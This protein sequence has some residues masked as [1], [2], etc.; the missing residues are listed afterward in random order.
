MRRIA[1]RAEALRGTVGAEAAATEIAAIAQLAAR[2]EA[3][4]T[5]LLAYARS[6][7]RDEAFRPVPIGDVA[8]A[9]AASRAAALA[10]VGGTVSVGSLPT[11]A[12]S[13]GMVQRML[14]TLIDTALRHRA[15]RRKLK[16]TIEP[17][18]TAPGTVLVRDNGRGIDR[19][20]VD[21]LFEPSAPPNADTDGLEGT[22][23]ALAICRRIMEA[24]GG[25]LD[26]EPSS[27]RGACFR[28]SFPVPR[29]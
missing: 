24:H 16:I 19:A 3:Q 15:P 4:V 1:A 22:G 12:G 14:E 27:S 13:A 8:R 2:S 28:L 9:A 18:T 26:V 29:E 11:V 5:E 21:S 25:S 20:S 17:D 23:M 6:A 7:P 10:A